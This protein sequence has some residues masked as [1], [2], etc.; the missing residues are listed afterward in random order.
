MVPVIEKLS[1][2]R[3]VHYPMHFILLPRT[4]NLIYLPFVILAGFVLFG[5]AVFAMADYY[6]RM[7]RAVEERPP[8]VQA[9]PAMMVIGLVYV[10][11]AG[12]PNLAATWLSAKINNVWA[13]RLLGFSGL[14]VGLTA[15]VLLVYSLLVVRREG[16]GPFRAIRKS[17]S[18]G[19]R[20]FWPTLFVVFSI[21]LVHRPIDAL[22]QY[23]DKVVLKFRPELVFFLLLAGVIL[24]LV[25]SFV[26][27]ASTTA[28]SLSR[29]DE[30]IG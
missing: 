12:A 9:I 24:E 21:Y 11:I 3:S 10:I 26:L 14:L 8:F 23:Q 18:I 7:G 16:C 13:G 20:R 28:L 25:T 27:F 5:R 2:E 17:V 6:G 29:R 30:G 4:Y 19:L 1:G 15:Q 22:I